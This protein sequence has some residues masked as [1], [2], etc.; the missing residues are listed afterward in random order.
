VFA[1]HVPPSADRPRVLILQAGPAAD[2]PEAAVVVKPGGA[3]G[4]F[5]A[6]AG[7]A[8]PDPALDNLEAFY[9]QLRPGGRLILAARAEP[10]ALLEAL[11]Q[12]GFQHC[13]VEPHPDGWVLYRGARPGPADLQYLSTRPAGAGLEGPFC[14]IPVEQT[15][16]KPAWRLAPSEV[17]IWRAPTVRDPAGGDDC[18]LVFTSLVRAVAFMQR[19]VLAGSITGINKVGKFRREQVSGWQRPYLV[20]PTFHD[21]R[22][23]A[24]GQAV[25]LEPAAAQAGDE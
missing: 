6:I 25:S 12:A 22:Q 7:Y 14:Y 3:D 4:L 9:R 5:D 13:L 2:L 1:K 20:N 18:L 16:N 8:A 10:K 24:R 11:V 19:A 21:V 23:R 15:P 17:V